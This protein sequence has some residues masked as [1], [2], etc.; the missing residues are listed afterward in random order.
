M[1][2]THD[3]FDPAAPLNSC[4]ATAAF[5]GLSRGLVYQQAREGG[6]PAIRIGSRIMVKTAPLLA[7]LGVEPR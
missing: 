7:S 6:L 3:T 1:P 2:K 5:L 4:E